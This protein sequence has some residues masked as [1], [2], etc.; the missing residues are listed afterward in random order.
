MQ[1]QLKKFNM[2]MIKDDQV[3]VMIGARNTGKS[4]LT[5]DL[6]YN[7]RH[8]PVGT[9]ISP[10]ENAN[11]F[12]SNIVPPI[13]IHDEYTPGVVSSFM[14]KQKRLKKRI[15]QGDKNLD[16]KAFLI[17]DDCLYDNEWK[18]DK[19]IREIFMN[20]RHW[21]I[22]FILIM[23]YALGVA[24][25]LRTN[26]D[27]I[28]IL[29]ENFVS[30]RKR[31]YEQYAGMF[32]TFE[33]FCSTMDQCTNNYECLVINRSSRS[34]KLEDQVFWYKADSHKDFKTCCPEAWRYSMENYV[35]DE[36]TDEEN[37]STMEEYLQAK[38]KGPFIRIQK[39]D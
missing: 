22:L 18:K 6:L 17:L 12:Y 38:R 39:T 34:N 25:N 19:R 10:T 20:G 9:V 23:Q 1:L 5:K 32:P 27:W 29:R 16:N 37:N 31:L 4:F 24:P 13:F 8:I 26:I 28:F 7:K 3:V 33:M 14:K 2:N 11:K 15:K 35:E 30:N 21:D 36:G